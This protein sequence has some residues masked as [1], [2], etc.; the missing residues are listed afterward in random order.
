M[1]VTSVFFFAALVMAAAGQR[2]EGIAAFNA[3]RYSDAL[4][5]LSATAPGDKTAQLFLALTQAAMGECGTALPVLTREPLEKLGGIAAVKCYAAT[6]EHGKEFA[7]LNELQKKFPSDA[8]VLYVTAKQH[9]KA[10]NE[11][12]LAMFEHAP[13]SYRVHEL[14]AEIFEVNNRFEE[15][16]AEYRKA[17]DLNATAPDLHFRLG[18]AL[19]MQSHS[20]DALEQAAKEFRAEL[21]L[22]PEDAS[23]HFQLGQIAQV[24]TKSPEARTEFNEAL[25]LSPDFVQALIA[26]G[27]LETSA[28]N[29]LRAIELLSHA[30]SLQPK[31]EAAHYALLT[32]YR[33]S[34]QMDRARQEKTLLDQLQRP[35]DGEFADFLKKLGAPPQQP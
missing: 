6:G 35:Q 7:L 13:A 3:G 9:M 27:K 16:I 34:G 31:N 19:L 30:T 20:P 12:T 2:D 24:E 1:Q 18:R 4:K 8:D 33:D 25:K 21:A 17:I 11:A 26:L 22:N 29:Y 15:A 23:C 5:K 14:S 28:K 10:F 32:A